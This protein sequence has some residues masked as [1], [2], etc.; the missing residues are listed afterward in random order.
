MGEEEV[1]EGKAGVACTY[2]KPGISYITLIAV[3]DIVLVSIIEVNEFGKKFGDQ[4]RK[5]SL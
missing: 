1:D 5:V 4:I 3:V 2:S